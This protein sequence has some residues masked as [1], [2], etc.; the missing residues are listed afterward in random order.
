MI[1]HNQYGVEAK[2]MVMDIAEIVAEKIRAMN[3]RVRYRDFYDFSMINK[4]LAIDLDE[5]IRLVKKKE[6]RKPVS[7]RNIKS[8]WRLAKGDKQNELQSIYFSEGLNDEEID[9]Y[10]SGLNFAEIRK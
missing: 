9:S 3:D 1:Y 10:L 8:N 2:V 5:V 4:K 6:I 7:S